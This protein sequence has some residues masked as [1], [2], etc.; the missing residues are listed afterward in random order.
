MIVHGM[1]L[2]VIMVFTYAD[3]QQSIQQFWHLF[4]GPTAIEYC[5]NAIV[6]LESM[7]GYGIVSVNATCSRH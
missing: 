6:R 4:T 2:S 5:N 1:I 7:T 3:G